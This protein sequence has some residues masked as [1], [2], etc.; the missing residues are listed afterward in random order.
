[1]L[2]STE[3][4]YVKALINSYYAKGYTN[5]VVH[6]VTE[7]NNDY[8]ICIYL[9]KTEI[10]SVTDNYFSIDDGLQIYIDSSGKSNYSTN[11]RDSVSRFDGY[12]TIDQAEFIYTNAISEY[13]LVNI[14][15]NPNLTIDYKQRI[16]DVFIIAILIIIF[17]YIFIRDLFQIGGR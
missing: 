12:V 5:Y 3:L 6:T 17:L 4:E 9:S 8:D 11:R 13:S 16:I 1:M 10:E 7:N 14:P 2:S 15:L